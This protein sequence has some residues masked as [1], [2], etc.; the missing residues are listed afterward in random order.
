MWCMWKELSIFF[1]NFLFLQLLLGLTAQQAVTVEWDTGHLDLS[2]VELRW[3][4]ASII[5]AVDW[6]GVIATKIITHQSSQWKYFFFSTVQFHIF[7]ADL[8]NIPHFSVVANSSR[9]TCAAR[10]MRMKVNNV[11]SCNSFFISGND[12]YLGYLGPN[13]IMDATTATASTLMLFADFW[14]PLA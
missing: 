4:I 7:R 13:D 2:I 14:N 5:L 9:V 6:K 12:C 10:C 11:T 8:A 3:N 1:Q